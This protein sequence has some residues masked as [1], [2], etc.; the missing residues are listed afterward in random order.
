M[1]KITINGT[2]VEEY[3]IIPGESE[4][5]KLA[6]E[7]FA[8]YCE[9]ISGK[10]PCGPGPK[11]I[12]FRI[13]SGIVTNPDGYMIRVTKERM[14]IYGGGNR[15][16]MYA[17]YDIFQKFY[18]VRYF[19]P[20]IEGLGNG[21][22]IPL[23]EYTYTPVFKSGNISVNVRGDCADWYI[24]NKINSNR[25][26]NYPSWH[27][28]ALRYAGSSGHSFHKIFGGPHAEI[29]QP[30]MTERENID[31]VIAYT[32]ETLK[33]NPDANV[34]HISQYDNW[35]TCKCEKCN[36][37]SA[38]EESLGGP[39]IRLINE[40]ADVVK[41]E[42]PGVLVETYA[43]QFS[44]KP[45]K[46]KPRDNVLIQFCPIEAC[47]VHP[48]YETACEENAALLEDFMG[49]KKLTNNISLFD[50][51]TNFHIH[52]GPFPDFYTIRE[53]MAFYAKMGVK[54]I[55][56]LGNSSTNDADFGELRAYLIARVLENPYISEVEYKKHMDEFL[57][58]Y[59][60]AGWRYIR[61][62]IDIIH[63][64]IKRHHMHENEIP[65]LLVDPN[66]IAEIHDFIEKLWD[67]AEEMAGDRIENV[68]RVRLQW[69]YL[70]LGVRPNVEKNQKYL[71]ELINR[72]VRW[73]EGGSH[74]ERMDVHKNVSL[75][76]LGKQSKIN[77]L[78][79]HFTPNTDFE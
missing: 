14:E 62:Y 10:C 52:V 73:S 18:G 15:G 33:K 75:W 46:T 42:F 57:E 11:D 68:R 66:Y 4:V 59:Y 35:N 69:T 51:V 28:Q 13:H 56:E 3:R 55:F 6:A 22:D 24:K 36:A 29:K 26:V 19:T 8:K 65:F 37:I 63:A 20:E 79:A 74:Y 50:Y 17:V 31:K 9:K 23:G 7:E 38:E 78:L 21:G 12:L 2:P 41:E 54:H 58:A 70:S 1:N 76:G 43:Y 27:V 32:R 16:M 61:T 48:I 60:G 49:W 40:V 5:E 47:F 72:N 67:K 64:E 39:L 45:P 25:G 34:I 71:N 53:N 44:R 30:C 77:R